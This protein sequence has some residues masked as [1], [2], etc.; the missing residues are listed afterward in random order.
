MGFLVPKS[1]RSP[2]LP[3][4]IGANRPGKE[5]RYLL[6][7]LWDFL[8]MSLPW[9]LARMEE[10][11]R[12]IE[13]LDWVSES[14]L[15]EKARDLSLLRSMVTGLVE[16]GS[17]SPSLAFFFV[18]GFAIFDSTVRVAVVSRGNENALFNSYT[19][20]RFGW[21]QSLLRFHSSILTK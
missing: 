12:W 20:F 3:P 16:S 6:L 11:L 8:M 17:C 2:I 4:A 13:D 18:F 5:K 7:F 21:Y 19:E 10:G 9:C 15:L 14:M 1:L